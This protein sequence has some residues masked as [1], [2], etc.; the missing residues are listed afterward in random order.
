MIKQKIKENKIL[1]I[2]LKNIQIFLKNTIIAIIQ[3]LFFIKKIEN[4]KVVVVNYYGKGFSDNGK[5]VVESLHNLRKDLKIIWL[6]KAEYNH[7]LPEY[8]TP[9]KYNSLKALYE[10]STAKIWIDNCRK[11]NIFLKRKKQYYVQ[12]WHGSIPLK[13]IEKDAE[14]TL[15]YEY[16]YRCKLD[17]KFAD[18]CIA[19]CDFSKNIFEKSFWYNGE[20]LC[21]GTPKD[22]IFFH[23]DKFKEIEKKVRNT[24]NIPEDKKILLYAPTFRN[25]NDLS[26]YNI[27]YYAL[28]KGL[29]EKIGKEYCILLRLHPNISQ[30][31]KELNIPKEI[32]DTSNYAD[33][34]ELM[35]SSDILITDYSSVMFEFSYMKRPV[36]LYCRDLENYTKTDRGLYFDIKKL[37]FI[38]VENNQELIS[39]IN[40]FNYDKYLKDLN[41]FFE[42]IGLKED[43]KSSEKIA[44]IIERKIKDE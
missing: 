38:F 20:I 22:D 34:N 8:I 5:Y 25:N 27:D 39:S 10:L 31:S 14:D 6:V 12:L 44:K 15:S 2:K 36:F 13:K 3:S 26:C 35:I 33:I 40:N 23:I 11:E 29:K 4:N 9:V 7:D 24:L 43:G 1:Y 28:L 16:I 19:S 21:E 37:P 42:N 17:S 32:I 18:L 30:R 41:N